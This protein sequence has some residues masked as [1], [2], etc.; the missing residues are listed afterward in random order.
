[1]KTKADPQIRQVVLT[2]VFDTGDLSLG[3]A[4]AETARHDYA[5][6]IIKMP[7]C[8]FIGNIGCVDPFY[9]N[10]AAQGDTGVLQGVDDRGIAV[11]HRCVLARDADGYLAIDLAHLVGEIAPPGPGLAFVSQIDTVLDFQQPGDLEIQ[12]N[13]S[14]HRRDQI[15][16]RRVWQADNSLE[17]NVAVHTDF[18]PDLFRRG[19]GRPA[20]DN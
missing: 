11:T 14:K 8:V 1:M 20:G 16:A 17:R 9:F 4:G 5:I 18:L 15:D 2:Y 7:R 6:D 13:L 10:L 3:A 12:A 19:A